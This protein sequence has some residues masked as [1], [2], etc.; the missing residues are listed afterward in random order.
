MK[1]KFWQT[2]TFKTLQETWEA[3]LRDDGFADAEIL[4][5]G[6]RI[7]RQRA[8]NAHRGACALDRHTKQEYYNLL[9]RNFHAESFSD[10]VEALIMERRSQGMKIKNISAELKSKGERCHRQTVGDIILKYEEKWGLKR[11]PPIK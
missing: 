5:N 6:R 11:K 1:Q 4:I 3:K 8:R 10:P 7:L 9:G 2:E